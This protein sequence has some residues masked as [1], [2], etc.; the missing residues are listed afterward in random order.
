M[1]II[2]VI[3]AAKRSLLLRYGTSVNVLQAGLPSILV[4]VGHEHVTHDLR[5]RAW[6]YP[7][8]QSSH[9]D[10]EEPLYLPSGHSTQVVK[11]AF[12]DVPIGQG[13]HAVALGPLIK[14]KLHCRQA[15]VPGAGE[16]LPAEQSVQTEEPLTEDFP[17]EQAMHSVE[18]TVLLT[19]PAAQSKQTDKPVRLE[20]CPAAQ[21]VQDVD[22]KEEEYLPISQSEQ[23]LII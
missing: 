12:E 8:G 4:K 17:T 10:P 19:L 23:A 13:V 1:I 2:R 5:S 22:A 6:I 21:R 9:V 16:N 14:P 15:E 11:S 3:E 18:P 7:R 20:N